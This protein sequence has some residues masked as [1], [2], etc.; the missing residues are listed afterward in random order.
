MNYMVRRTRSAIFGR[1]T[2][3]LTTQIRLDSEYTHKICPHL[4]IWS[5]PS[6]TPLIPDRLKTSLELAFS[7][8][9]REDG[10][11]GAGKTRKR[12]PRPLPPTHTRSERGTRVP[13][14]GTHVADD[15]D[16]DREGRNRPC[17]PAASLYLSSALRACLTPPVTF[18][19]RCACCCH[20]W[21]CPCPPQPLRAELGPLQ[22][23]SHLSS[24]R[25]T[26]YWA[27]KMDKASNGPIRG[28]HMPTP[29]SELQRVA[30]R[31][32]CGRVHQFT[33][34][35][36]AQRRRSH[37]AAPPSPPRMP[38]PPQSQ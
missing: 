21:C 38:P 32:S 7:P 34:A 13:C 29:L 4:W 23:R 12:I 10:A 24:L 28:E 30:Q 5:Y 14:P 1:C 22:R 16:L 11:N 37:E 8:R 36:W 3:F 9:W 20:S 18:H 2:I 27:I 15:V 19:T 6:R 25:F 31:T 35:S 33:R 17:T 26:P